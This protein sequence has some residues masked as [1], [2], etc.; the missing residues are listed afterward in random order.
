[1]VENEPA[2]NETVIKVDTEG[3][4]DIKLNAAKY[5]KKIWIFVIGSVLFV[6]MIE[7]LKWELDYRSS[8]G[9]N[10]IFRITNGKNELFEINSNNGSFSTN[11]AV[12][13]VK[14]DKDT[15]KYSL[16]TVV[17]ANKKNMDKIYDF[18]KKERSSMMDSKVI[19]SY[20]EIT[21]YQNYES[22]RKVNTF[23]IK[24][25]FAEFGLHQFE[26]L[27]HFMK[28]RNI[29]TNGNKPLED[30]VSEI[31]RYIEDNQSYFDTQKHGFLVVVSPAD[32]E[33]IFGV[34]LLDSF[35]KS[36]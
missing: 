19:E 6:T 22:F 35:I 8:K 14:S 32:G 17:D 31:K 3:K 29:T 20:C 1:M 15:S 23:N 25:I 36:L 13:I 7:I 34:P 5:K 33:E 11:M 30:L 12:L 18:I 10:T 2:L 4:D 24:A 16:V 9:R 21:G 26:S 27:P 28:R